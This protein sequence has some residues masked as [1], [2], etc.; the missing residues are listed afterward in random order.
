VNALIARV[1]FPRHVSEGPLNV[2]PRGGIKGNR[3]T[4]PKAEESIWSSWR[5]GR[6]PDEM[7]R[8]FPGL[9]RIFG[10]I[11][12]KGKFWGMKLWMTME[13]NVNTSETSELESFF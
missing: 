1:N 2:Y 9:G 10:K 3:N 7:Q 8:P 11:S 4:E 13:S 5:I 12:G 6:A